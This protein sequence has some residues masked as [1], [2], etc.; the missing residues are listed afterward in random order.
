MSARSR[1]VV[2]RSLSSFVD[3]LQHAFD[4]EELAKKK[5]L[6]QCLDPRVKIVG[7][8]SLMLLCALARRLRVIFALFVFAIVLAL[9]SKL[10]MATLAKRVWLTVLAFTGFIS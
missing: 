1:G 6:L 4:A 9:L 10:P 5:G 8:L 3:A 2:E 7:I